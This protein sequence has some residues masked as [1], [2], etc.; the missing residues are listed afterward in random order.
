MKILI[1]EDDFTCR[2]AL[3]SMLTPYGDVHIAANGNEAI[4]ALTEALDSDSPYEL[5]CLDIMMPDLDG[6]EVLKSFRY[7]EEKKGI[8]LGHGAKIIMTTA[9]KD[10]KNVLGAFQEQCDAYLVKPIDKGDL[11]KHLRELKL[12]PH[13]N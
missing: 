12:L 11:L 1:V 7:A 5:I 13:N 8:L 3:Q 2:T 4:G 10:G 6:Q 9:L